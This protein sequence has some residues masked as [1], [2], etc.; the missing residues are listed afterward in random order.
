M[1]KGRRRKRNRKMEGRG[2]NDGVKEEGK[3]E[4]AHRNTG[5]WEQ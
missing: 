1:M 5:I 4:E 2:E 3:K